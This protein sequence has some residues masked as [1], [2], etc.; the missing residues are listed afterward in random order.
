M[1]NTKS[2]GNKIAESRKKMNYSQSELVQKISISPQAVGKWESGES[3]PDLLTLVRLSEI[4]GVDLNYFTE[5]QKS[6]ESKNPQILLQQNSQNQVFTKLKKPGLSWNMSSSSWVDSDFSGLSN[7]NNQLSS[8]N[9]KNCKFIGS[10]L[11]DLTLKSNQIVHS[12]FSNSDLRN[13]NI[14]SSY[15]FNNQYVNCSL[16]D[17]CFKESEINKCDFTNANFSGIEFKSIELTNCIFNQVIWNLSAFESS[18][19]SN[20][21]FNSNLESCSF[22]N[23]SFSK[24]IFNKVS[25]TNTFFKGKKLKGIQFIDC[26]A[27]RL[28]YEFLKNAKV[29]L[30]GLTL[31]E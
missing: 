15:L 2:I 11:A 23:C 10:N 31:M 26:F 24:V 3:M 6:E 21:E 7:I 13:C 12:N 27:D 25:L 8:S 22:E 30:N 16:I 1:L 29:D 28:T 20:M 4:F 9:I 5:S 17:A 19:L 18:H 14:H